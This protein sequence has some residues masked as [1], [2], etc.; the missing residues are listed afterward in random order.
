MKHPAETGEAVIIDDSK[1]GKLTLHRGP[2]TPRAAQIL[3]DANLVGRV[4]QQQTDAQALADVRTLDSWAN[5]RQARMW[6][7]FDA[8]THWECS[9]EQALS[10][11]A[12]FSCDGATPD[13][14][15]AAAAAW[16]R[17]QKAGT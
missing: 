3:H 5:G 4:R 12:E 13:E 9:G 1:G 15:R 2:R 17:G 16:V 8:G 10:G 11:E 7:L 14:A 6:L